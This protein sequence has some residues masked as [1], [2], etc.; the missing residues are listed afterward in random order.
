MRCRDNSATLASKKIM[1]HQDHFRHSRIKIGRKQQKLRHNL[2]ILSE[3]GKK[4]GYSPRYF[5]AVAANS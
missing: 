3:E 4:K 5:R 1:S 2:A